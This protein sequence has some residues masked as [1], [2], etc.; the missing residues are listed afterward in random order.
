MSFIDC[1]KV[2]FIYNSFQFICLVK[3]RIYKNSPLTEKYAYIYKL[4]TSTVSIKC[5]FNTRRFNFNLNLIS[6]SKD[7]L[8]I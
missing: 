8:K 2:I 6:K 3:K 1:N 7:Y 5:F 4:I